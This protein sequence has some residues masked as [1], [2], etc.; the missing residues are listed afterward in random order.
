MSDDLFDYTAGDPSFEQ[1]AHRNGTSLWR[2]ADLRR[3]L[4]YES[5]TTFRRVVQKAQAACLALGIPIEEN[6]R[7]GEPESPSGL[8]EYKLTRFA[9]FLTAM[10]GDPRKREVAAAQAYF[11]ALADAIHEWAGEPEDVERIVMREDVAGGAKL[12]NSVASRH[13]VEHYGLFLDAG[14]RGMYNKSLR[15]L[16]DRKGVPDG[17]ILFDYM[18]KTEL[19]ANHFRLTQTAEKIRAYDVR[20]QAAL[21][22][23]AEGVGRTVRQTML[24]ISGTRPEDLPTREPIQS[25]R[26]GLKRTSRGFKKLDSGRRSASSAGSEE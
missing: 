24:K 23:V 18:G 3:A 9:C 15:A 12:L 5:P 14:Y 25:V 7:L 20:G 17:K 2:E 1:L 6:F 13:G 26:S 21:E 19:A 11:A 22:N 10:N 16:M 4:G 8:R